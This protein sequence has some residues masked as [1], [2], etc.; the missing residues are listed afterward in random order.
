MASNFLETN[1]ER[2]FDYGSFDVGSYFVGTYF[3]RALLFAVNVS[4]LFIWFDNST[5][6]KIELFFIFL[7]VTIGTGR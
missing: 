5:V 4:R 3:D 6:E 2:L 1:D 7:I